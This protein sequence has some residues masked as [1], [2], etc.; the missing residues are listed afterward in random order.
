MPRP[1]AGHISRKCAG[2]KTNGDPCKAWAQHHSDYCVACERKRSGQFK[3]GPLSPSYKHGRYAKVVPTKLLQAYQDGLSDP[4]LLSQK[5]EVAV[6]RARL[7]QLIGR[8]ET[9]ESDAAWDSLKNAK[10]EFELHVSQSSPVSQQ[11]AQDALQ[12]IMGL[13]DSGHSARLAWA[14]VERL[15]ALLDKLKASERKRLMEAKAFVTITEAIAMLQTITW[16]LKEIVPKEVE[17]KGAQQRILEG[18]A[19]AVEQMLTMGVLTGKD[20]AA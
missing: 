20:N 3:P 8:T 4:E 17:D 18:M 9:G 1:P 7:E 15:T 10:H 14:D 5:D 19:N 12:Q 6:L 16:T 13:I 11:K 2:K